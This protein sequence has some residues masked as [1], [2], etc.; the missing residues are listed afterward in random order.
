[1]SWT[2]PRRE[3]QMGDTYLGPDGKQYPAGMERTPQGLQLMLGGGSPR[4]HEGQA[5]L[6]GGAADAA[7][8]AAEAVRRWPVRF[9]EPQSVGFVLMPAASKRGH[10]PP[11]HRR[12][13]VVFGTAALRR[14]C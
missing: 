8:K 6:V 11:I 1:M 5:D 12:S 7:E 2:L 3:E 4:Q 14:T 9:G 13:S 10:D